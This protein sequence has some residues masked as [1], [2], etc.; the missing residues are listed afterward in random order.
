MFAR[1]GNPYCWPNDTSDFTAG[2]GWPSVTKPS[3]STDGRKSYHW[4]SYGEKKNIGFVQLYTLNQLIEF[5]ESSISIGILIFIYHW[6]VVDLPLWKIW[7]R[8]LGWWNSQLNGKII[9]SCSKP[10]ASNSYHKYTH[11]PSGFQD[12]FPLTYHAL[13]RFSS[14]RR[15][16]WWPA[17]TWQR[18]PSPSASPNP[19][20]TRSPRWSYL[21]LTGGYSTMAKQR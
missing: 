12:I 14:K 20:P 19:T 18:S 2:F 17:R 11:F 15:G 8:Q 21:G 5:I 13:V 16:C 9:H 7:L 10:P 4:N 3:R 1:P 6:L